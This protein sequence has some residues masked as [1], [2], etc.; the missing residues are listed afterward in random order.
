MKEVLIIFVAIEQPALTKIA[1]DALIVNTDLKTADLLVVL[2]SPCSAVQSMIEEYK[3]PPFQISEV[4]PRSNYSKVLNS[5]IQNVDH[6]YLAFVHNDTIV[7]KGWLAKALAVFEDYKTK[8]SKQSAN[9][10]LVELVGVSPYQS[11][12]EHPFLVHKN[13]AQL[14][15]KI[16]PPTKVVL[17]ESLIEELLLRLFPEGLEAFAQKLTQQS[18][19][20]YSYVPEITSSCGVLNRSAFKRVCGYF[21][22]RFL[23]AGGEIRLACRQLAQ[24]GYLFA[25]VD[26]S[27]VYHHGNLTND[28]PVANY[29]Q[30]LQFNNQLLAKT[31]VE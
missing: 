24:A 20:W 14:L 6:K 18:D 23:G 21:D 30:L 31:E 9:D 4:T 29:E 27:F 19:S 3:D 16:K 17:Q 28:G 8:F 12:C 7:T 26:N 22:E 2:N 15:S 11:Y 5:V 10:E 1:L 13:I 25:R